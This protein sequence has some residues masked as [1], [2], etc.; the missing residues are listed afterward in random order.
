[1]RRAGPARIGSLFTAICGLYLC[2]AQ[3]KSLG[4]R[5]AGILRQRAVAARGWS[6][7]PAY[8]RARL[9]LTGTQDKPLIERET[10]SGLPHEEIL[11]RANANRPPR[12]EF[13][14]SALAPYIV[15][16]MATM[17]AG[18]VRLALDR[19]LGGSY[20]Y[21]VFMLSVLVAARYGGW[22]PALLA[23][24]LGLVLANMFFVTP[25]WS[26]VSPQWSLESA[27]LVGMCCFLVVSS[28]A[29]AFARSA[30]SAQLRSDS[31]ARQ[32]E[33]EIAAHLDTQADLQRANESLEARVAERTAE[34]VAAKTQAETA[35]RAKSEFLANMSHEIRTPMTAILGFADLALDDT[36]EGPPIKESVAIIKRNGEHLLAL[37][38]DILDL[39]KI[40]SGKLAIEMR[41]GSPRTIVSDVLALFK[42]RAEEKGL[43]LR[44]AFDDSLPDAIATDPAR[45]RQVLLNVVGNAIKFT[46]QG[47]VDLRVRWET[48]PALRPHLVIE[49]QDTGIG[50]TGEQMSC[51][52]QAFQQADGSTSRR[53]G[54]TGLGLA[55]SRQLTQMLGGTIAVTSE[56]GSGSTFCI[57]VPGEPACRIDERQYVSDSSIDARC[58]IPVDLPTRALGGVR[59]LLADDS[60]DNRKLISFV[61][62]HAGALV[63]T[64]ENGQIAC[65]LALMAQANNEAFDVV[66]MDMQMPV[67]DGYLATAELRRQ[68]YGLPI[69]ALTAHSM[70][71]D[72]QKCLD[73]GCDAYLTK[74]IDQMQLV[75][76]I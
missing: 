20:P 42:F 34:L 52:F 15:A 51:L 27:N 7:S 68:G 73:A 10:A 62:Q 41:L 67:V 19:Q 13:G 8:V 60:P 72:R 50:M 28:A 37:I 35:T 54:G 63:T 53:F 76:V 46:E 23:A 4:S 32:L 18:G 5:R 22:K 39:A 49:V 12:R 48:G 65:D 21:I 43:R 61:L 66:L 33:R 2:V 74:P 6:V 40:E 29:V 14:L 25:R 45:L 55:I 70:P 31:Y 71:A 16:V 17:I 47:R 26:F 59:V 58:K 30:R 36:F 11:D 75:N 64:A 38:N 57:R 3:A 24:S 1:M 9:A 44:A 69:I 56:F